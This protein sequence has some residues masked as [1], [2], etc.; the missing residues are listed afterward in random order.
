MQEQK[1]NLVLVKYV[2]YC[3]TVKP[4][5]FNTSSTIEKSVEK[6]IGIFS[7]Q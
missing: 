1:N 3:D 2:I 5:N 4:G 6:R 7:M